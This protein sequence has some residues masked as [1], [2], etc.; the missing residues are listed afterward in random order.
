MISYFGGKNGSGTL[1]FLIN[2]FPPHKV[3]LEPFLGSGAIIRNKKPAEVNIGIEVN[4]EVIDEYHYSAGYTVI[5]DCAISYLKKKLLHGTYDKD[6]FIYAD[7]PYLHSTR[8]SKTRY[9]FEL[10]ELQHRQLIKILMSI[11]A[12]GAKIAISHYENPIYNSLLKKWNKWKYKNQT[13]SGS[14]TEVLYTNYSIPETLHD[15]NFL[16]KNFTDRQRIKRKIARHVDRLKELPAQ[17]RNAILHALGD[18]K[19]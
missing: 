2:H 4:Q 18:L 15:Y 14:V 16:G 11:S 1:Q 3:Y 19:T 5:N 6:Y 12:E 8:K 10:T 13:R 7:P 17:E 9:K